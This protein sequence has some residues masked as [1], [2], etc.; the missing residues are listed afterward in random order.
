[1]GD[2]PYRQCHEN[3]AGGGLSQQST[4]L[5]RILF[6]L[7]NILFILIFRHVFMSLSANT[8]INQ[9]L[10]GSAL[11]GYELSAGS[12]SDFY[13]NSNSLVGMSGRNVVRTHPYAHPQHMKVVKHLLYI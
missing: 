4:R 8:N 10:F 13:Q 3:R 11:L 9:P 7:I 1:M 12:C 2:A 5:C 6:I